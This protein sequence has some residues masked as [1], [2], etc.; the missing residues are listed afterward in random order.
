M[1][2]SRGQIPQPMLEA[3]QPRGVVVELCQRII[4]R[5]SGCGLLLDLNLRLGF[6]PYVAGHA[7]GTKDTGLP[8]MGMCTA[9]N[10]IRGSVPALCI[11]VFTYVRAFGE[12]A[13]RSNSSL[14]HDSGN[15]GTSPTSVSQLRAAPSA[16]IYT[17]D[18]ALHCSTSRAKHTQHRHNGSRRPNAHAATWTCEEACKA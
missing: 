9:Q 8:H 3:A 18:A 15:V 6:I 16:H 1:K 14:I 4:S 17:D 10:L 13:C 12:R 7:S 5:E 2:G 11:S